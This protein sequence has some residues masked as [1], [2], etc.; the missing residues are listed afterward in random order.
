MSGLLMV[1]VPDVNGTR[2]EI[3]SIQVLRGGTRPDN[4]DS[5][6][7]ENREYGFQFTYPP[8]MSVMEEPNKV[9]VTDEANCQMTIA[10]RRAEEDT[11]ITDVGEVAGQLK[12]YGEV[13]FLGSFVQAVL[14]IQDGYITAAYLVEP[15]VEL[16]E[17]TPLR[18]V[19]SIENTEGDRLSNSQVDWMLTIFENFALH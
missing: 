15:G 2:I 4:I 8:F 1:G 7:Y 9:I 5:S 14:N 12:N 11:Q 17:G 6:V 19:I 16:G 18:F 13:Y 10:Y 3:S